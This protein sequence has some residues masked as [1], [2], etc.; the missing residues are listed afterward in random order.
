MFKKFLTLFAFASFLV[1]G[2]L[3][4]SPA[5]AW[6]GVT[7][8]VRDSVTN[9]SEY[10]QHGGHAY[11]INQTTGDIVA[12]AALPIG[13]GSLILNHGTTCEFAGPCVAPSVGHVI[14]I[15]IDF[16]CQA[17]PTDCPGT[18]TSGTP[19]TF[20]DLTYTQNTTPLRIT[21]NVTTGTGPLAVTLSGFDAAPGFNTT[22][23]IAALFLVLGGASLFALR[24]QTIRA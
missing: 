5:A 2:M 20:G 13:G 14:E 9:P 15:V 1:A 3:V 12:S 4:A 6:T 8:H 10:W 16:E 17:D 24:R 19:D 21:R 18:N 11:L 7:L 23:A 22:Y